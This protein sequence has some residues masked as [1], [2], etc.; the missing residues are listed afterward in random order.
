[1]CLRD[2]LKHLKDE[3]I[4][5]SETQV[6]WAIISHKID[7]PPLD[8]SLRFDFSEKHLR[9]IQELFDNSKTS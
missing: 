1:M 4:S 2:L 9:Q 7:R 6:R 3:G 8:G 5:V